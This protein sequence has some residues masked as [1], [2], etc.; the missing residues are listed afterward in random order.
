M[1]VARGEMPGLILLP[2]RPKE[3]H[4]HVIASSIVGHGED[5]CFD[6]SINFTGF[7][8]LRKDTCGLRRDAGARRRRGQR[9]PALEEGGRGQKCPNYPV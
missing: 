8:R 4:F 5:G 3:H 6:G 1:N 2:N 9:P 7:G